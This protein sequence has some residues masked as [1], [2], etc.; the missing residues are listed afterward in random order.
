ML[1][2]L[3]LPLL[4]ISGYNLIFSIIKNRDAL[5]LHFFNFLYFYIYGLCG[6]YSFIDFDKNKEIYSMFERSDFYIAFS[7]FIVTITYIL[8]IYFYNYVRKIYIPD[9]SNYLNERNLLLASN[10]SLLMCFLFIIVYSAQYGGV[11]NAL[12]YSAVIRA[13]YGEIDDGSKLT[14]VKYLMPI[15][16]FPFLMYG[17]KYVQKP[18]IYIA[19]L[20]FLSF[21]IVFFAFLLMSGRTRIVIYILAMLII[22]SYVN[23]NKFNVLKFIKFLPLIGL[24]VFIVIEGKNLFSSLGD[25]LDGSK[26]SEVVNNNEKKESFL[27]AFLGY[28]SHRTYSLEA[29]LSYISQYNNLYW[30]RD[31]FNMPLYLIPERLTGI[32]KPDSI[33]Y[34]NTEVLTGVYDSMI[35]PGILAYGSYSMWL[36]GIIISSFIFVGFFSLL[37]NFFYRN[38]E[39]KYLLVFTLPCIVVWGLY[40]SSGDFRV[41]TNSFSYI[42]VFLLML[43]VFKILSK[44]R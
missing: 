42:L 18:K 9:F 44:V 10:V 12:Q 33:S 1:S 21:I 19:I 14:F 8:S 43:I 31:N 15:G 2:I 38:K 40:G 35:P 20:W 22:V 34:Y 13:G 3:Y 23:K 16:V 26:I 6:L 29:S 24:A 7:I 39:K 25:L 28:F 36:P 4:F 41:L 17:Y 27:E 30:F 37:D 5:G 32:V 11:Y